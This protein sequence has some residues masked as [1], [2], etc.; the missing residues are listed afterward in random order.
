MT[1]TFS[2]KNLIWPEPTAL[3]GAFVFSD[4][5]TEVHPY[6]MKRAYG[7]ILLGYDSKLLLL[8]RENKI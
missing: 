1:N 2:E 4:K 8:G 7:S 5:W 3:L 6:K